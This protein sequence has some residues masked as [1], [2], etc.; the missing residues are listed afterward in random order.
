MT[1]QSQALCQTHQL[2]ESL[3]HPLRL[4]IVCLLNQQGEQSLTQL[5]TQ[6]Q[7]SKPLVWLHLGK[8]KTNGL[9]ACRSEGNRHLYALPDNPFTN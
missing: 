8:L 9:V 5:A 1:P 2:V 4:K 3:A 6:L 7:R